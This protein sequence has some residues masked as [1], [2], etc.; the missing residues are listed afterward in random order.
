MDDSSMRVSDAD[1]DEAVAVLREH[2]LAGR[3][4]LEEFSER[5]EAAL[6]A[7]S[8]PNW[9]GS[10]TTCPRSRSPRA[11]RAGCTTA[12]ASFPPEVAQVARRRTSQMVAAMRISESATSQPLSIYWKGQ[13]RPAGW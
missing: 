8:A 10:R 11:A 1:R 4:T 9:P 2:L 5:V 7:G 6:Q 13:N 12:G 3:L